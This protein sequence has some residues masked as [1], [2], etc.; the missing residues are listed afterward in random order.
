MHVRLVTV[1][2]LGVLEC[3]RKDE[4]ETGLDGRWLTYV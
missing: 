2:T 3:L 1:I 4:S